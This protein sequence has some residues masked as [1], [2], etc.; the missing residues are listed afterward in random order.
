VSED[1]NFDTHCLQK[2][3]Y[4]ADFMSIIIIYSLLIVFLYNVCITKLGKR[5]CEKIV[6][7]GNFTNAYFISLKNFTKQY[8][9]G[10][11][12]V[13]EFMVLFSMFRNCDVRVAQMGFQWRSV[14][15]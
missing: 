2:P 10:D 1:P 15:E 7:N 13:D 6:T 8:H 12:D 3:E 11:E 5:S 9:L 4:H 14:W